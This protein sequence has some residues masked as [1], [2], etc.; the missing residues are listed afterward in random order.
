MFYYTH[1][2][3][4]FCVFCV[5]RFIIHHH[6]QIIINSNT[7]FCVRDERKGA[8]ADD[9]AEAT[10]A[11][12]VGGHNPFDLHLDLGFGSGFA[13][14]APALAVDPPDRSAALG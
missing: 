6:H 14:R 8:R 10:V 3:S 5:D 12:S 7:F 1:L 11:P 13:S 2:P 4:S 9:N